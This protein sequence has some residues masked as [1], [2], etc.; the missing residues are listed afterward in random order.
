VIPPGAR[1]LPTYVAEATEAALLEEIDRAPWLSDLKRRVQ[2]YG[3]RYDYKARRVTAESY[4]GPLPDWLVSIAT[5]LSDDGLFVET[6]DQVV[7]NEYLPGQGISA[8]IDCE[9]C[10]GEII[11]SLSLA[12]ASVM[13]FDSVVGAQR[14]SH[15][16]EPRSLLLLQGESR[17]DWRHG[18]PARKSDTLDGAVV[19][20]GRRVSVTFRNVIRVG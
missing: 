7:V 5:R 4:L 8:H 16:L 14:S 15:L 3:Y 17:F 13:E 1:Y 6:P 10:F 18:I 19:P 11:A 2:H 9:P 20:R 12:S